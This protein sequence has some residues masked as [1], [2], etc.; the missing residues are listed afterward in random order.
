MENLWGPFGRSLGSFGV[1]RGSLGGHLASMGVP[2]GSLEAPLGSLGAPFGILG[3]A[4]GVLLGSLGVLG[5]LLG[6]PWAS[7]GSLGGSWL[8]LG[9]F[10]EAFWGPK[11]MFLV[12]FL[13]NF[14]EHHAAKVFVLSFESSSFTNHCLQL[15]DLQPCRSLHSSMQE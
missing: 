11:S 12:S 14:L 5:V 7:S 13:E 2:W 3:G 4:L 8:I 15:A 6:V 1:P 9:S 10:W